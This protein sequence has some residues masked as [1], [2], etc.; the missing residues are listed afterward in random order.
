[1][2]YFNSES[3]KMRTKKI[4]AALLIC[5]WAC[6]SVFAQLPD[7]TKED[8]VQKIRSEENKISA[9]NIKYKLSGSF[10]PDEKDKEKLVPKVVIE[11]EYA[12]N[13]S[14]GHMYLHEKWLS[15]ADKQELERKYAY[16]GRTGTRL[17]LKQPGD[18]NRM[19]G[20]ITSTIPDAFNDEALWKPILSTY[21]YIGTNDSLSVAIEKDVNAKVVP[22]EF[23][24][25]QVYKVTFSVAQPD[26]EIINPQTGEKHIIKPRGNYAA[27]LSPEKSFRP[28][29]I[30][31]FDAFHSEVG[32][33]LASD[34]RE[35][36]PG[37]W[38]PWKFERFSREEQ[39]PHY[40]INVD[41]ITLNENA[42][43]ISSIKF[44]ENTRVRDER[45]GMRYLSTGDD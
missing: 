37:I 34:F 44:P 14:K 10:E 38:L 19:Y 17:T 15:M 2:R 41:S 12:N 27:L 21:E 13:I 16:D 6:H 36:M 29:K 20:Y 40:V 9:Y 25:E 32:V 33:C 31:E 43:V 30:A 1:M 35:I 11:F 24:G 4:V 28:V 26:M 8:L 3:F 39:N 45:T 42:N 5:F 7:I 23:N 18:P 22:D